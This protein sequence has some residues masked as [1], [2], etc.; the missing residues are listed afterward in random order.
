M[1]KLRDIAG[2]GAVWAAVAIGLALPISTALDN[3][4]LFLVLLMG[5]L[6]GA[7][8]KHWA[9]IRHNPVAIAVL[10]LGGLLVAGSFH[11]EG[12][13]SDA[14]SVLGKYADI[15][16]IVLLLPLFTESRYRRYGLAFF[17][18]AMAL[19]LV[20]SYLIWFGAFEGTRYFTE[21]TMGN[22]VVFKL[23]ITHGIF[24]AFAAY[25]F[26]LKARSEI[27]Q[28]RVLLAAL[29]LL[30][31]FNVLFMVQGRT[32][33]LVLG[34]LGIY[35][36]H[37]LMGRRALWF[38]VAAATALSMVGYTVSPT[39]QGRVDIAL[40]EAQVWQPGQGSNETSS[41]GTRMDYYTNTLKIIVQHP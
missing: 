33:Y 24:M 25:L 32:G 2:Q 27:G 36:L 8:W 12:A 21:R 17:M 9:L 26:A 19:T 35:Y 28:M 20:L 11:G 16:F 40:H 18:T 7:F 41:I 10:L 13:G 4:L 23:H 22:P 15:W 3:V 37:S 34:V 5:I 29:A 39:L 30:A 1:H 38:G 6:S 14:A 31:A